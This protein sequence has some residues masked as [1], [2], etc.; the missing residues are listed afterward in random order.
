MVNDIENT[1]CVELRS[2]LVVLCLQLQIGGGMITASLL[3]A[4][5]P[6]VFVFILNFFFGF[7]V[8][9]LYFFFVVV[10]PKWQNTLPTRFPC[11]EIPV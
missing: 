9:V 10:V 6:F 4:V 2:H 5:H 3:N 7:F 8:V 11:I 1:G